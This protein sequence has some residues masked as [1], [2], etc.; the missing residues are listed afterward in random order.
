M[1]DKKIKNLLNALLLLRPYGTLELKGSTFFLPTFY[2]YGVV[3]L[4]TK[5]W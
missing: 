2:P 5:C 4:G 1:T 3:P